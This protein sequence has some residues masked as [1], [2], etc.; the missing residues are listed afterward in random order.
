[1]SPTARTLPAS[2]SAAYNWAGMTAPVTAD[3]VYPL[4]QRN[5]CQPFDPGNQG[6]ISGK[7]V[8]LDYECGSTTSG[9]NLI[10]AGAIG[11]ILVDTNEQFDIFITGKSEIPMVSAP[12]SVGD[13]L[14]AELGGTVN[15]T[16]DKQYI[17]SV[18]YTDKHL[19]DTL[20]TFS[21]RG[22]RRD[23]SIL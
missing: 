3:L 6:L 22:P 10:A 2:I 18:P 7:I 5:G 11:A 9:A 16:L 4:T 17:A 12:K 8:L 1:N 14:K 20:S 21:S 15:V 19:V 13:M 23:G